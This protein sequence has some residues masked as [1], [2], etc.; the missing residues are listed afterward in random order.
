MHLTTGQRTI[1]ETRLRDGF[2]PYEEGIGSKPLVM[3]S[4]L[5]TLENV[6]EGISLLHGG[7]TAPVDPAEPAEPAEP[8][9]AKKAKK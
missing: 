2:N 6:I 3:A 1:D 4:Q 9:P 7:Q 8:A 5:D